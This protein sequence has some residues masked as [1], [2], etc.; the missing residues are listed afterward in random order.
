[1]RAP[2]ALP[3]PCR[4]PVGPLTPACAPQPTA[5]AGRVSLLPNAEMGSQTARVQTTHCQSAFFNNRCCG[6]YFCEPTTRRY[7]SFSWN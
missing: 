6:N 4:G 3:S 5:G 1:M 2:R 7:R